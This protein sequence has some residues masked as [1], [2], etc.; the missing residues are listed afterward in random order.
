[1]CGRTKTSGADIVDD[2][3]QSTRTPTT[4]LHTVTHAWTSP[5]ACLTRA[6]LITSARRNQLMRRGYRAI[7]ARLKESLQEQRIARQDILATRSPRA[8]LYAFV[9]KERKWLNP[10]SDHL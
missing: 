3:L 6:K 5:L 8:T 1:M 10:V 2:S 7:I 9:I 4:T